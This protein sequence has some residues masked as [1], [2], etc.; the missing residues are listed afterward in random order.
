[1]KL[2]IQILFLFLTWFTNPVNAMPLF[3]KFVLPSH[4]LSFSK[5]ENVK[6]ESIVKIGIQNFA[7]SDIENQFLSI[8]NG[9]VW[10]CVSCFDDDIKIYN[11]RG[12]YLEGL[13]NL[14]F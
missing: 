4:E 2:L 10:A 12:I 1:M 9:G 6:N 3:A 5:T 14:T 13:Q 7:R 8:S 11:R